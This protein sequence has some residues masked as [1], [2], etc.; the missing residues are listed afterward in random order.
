MKNVVLLIIDEISMVSNI[1]LMYINLCLCKIYNTTDTD[2]GW[3]GKIHVLFFGD[4]L[5]LSPVMQ[6]PPF[7]C[8]SSKEFQN[9]YL[10]YMLVI[11]GKIYLHTANL[12]L[13]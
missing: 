13:I 5:L 3:F 11:F 10:A 4:L 7:V 9:T 6:S 8:L 12:L 2:N 1:T